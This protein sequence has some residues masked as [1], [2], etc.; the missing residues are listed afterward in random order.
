MKVLVTQEE[1][2]DS[3][4]GEVARSEDKHPDLIEVY[5]RSCDIL[6]PGDMLLAKMETHGCL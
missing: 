2:S 5:R 4:Q 3:L 1:V 6:I